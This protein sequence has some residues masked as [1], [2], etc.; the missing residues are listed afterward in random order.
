MNE[1]YLNRGDAPFSPEI[2]KKI[3]EAVIETAKSQLSA[4]KL[5]HIEGPYG[6][7]MK[8]L[9]GTDNVLAEDS[10]ITVS[11]GKVIPVAELHG[12]FSLGARDIATYEK[13]GVP[14]DLSAAVTAAM[15]IAKLEDDII[16]NGSK[17]LGVEGL[18][19]AKGVQTL[20]LKPWET[21][22]SAVE[23][24]IAA[25]TKLDNAGLHGPYSLGLSAELYNMMFRRSEKGFS[26]EM[27]DI[28]AIVTDGIVKLPSIKSGGVLIASGIQFA[29]IVLGQD[30]MVGYIGPSGRGYDF[31]VSETIALRLRVPESVCVMS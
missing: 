27:Q 6:L 5:L 10:G 14:F 4:R 8:S 7:G 24:I 20:K 29:S 30:L 9:P 21:V 2:W 18:L 17:A 11:A 25:V 22:G 16:L 12:K 3:D 26:T 31:T 19:T 15:N 1:R 13:S 23:N 28:E